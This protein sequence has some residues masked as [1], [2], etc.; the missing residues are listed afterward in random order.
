MLYKVFL[1]ED[2]IVTRE[3]I[4]DN[5][6]WK[7]A[8]FEFCGEAPDGEM[9]LPLIEAT[10]PDLLITDIKMPFMDGLQLCKIIREHMP[11]IKIIILSGHDEFNY[12]QTAIKL[13][14]AEYLLKPVS[15]KDLHQV[16]QRTVVKLDQERIERERLKQLREQLDD[17]L[18]LIR[19]KFLLRLVLGGVS[20]AEAIEQSEQLG[21]DL[22]A[23]YYLALLIKTE[24]PESSQPNAYQEYQ[25]VGHTI[26][27][28]VG[29]NPDILWAQ[30]DL[31]ELVLLMKGDNLEQLNQEA[32]FLAGLIK[33]EVEEKMSCV[34]RIGLGSPQQRLGEIHHSYAEALAKAGANEKAP[35]QETDER[36]DAI[37]HAKLDQAALE[38]YLKSGS[39]L[40]FNLFFDVY[41]QPVSEAAQRSRLLKQYI[42]LDILLTAAQFVSDLGGDAN[43]VLPEIGQV[44]TLMEG[45]K[46][47]DEIKGEIRKILT[48]V[49]SF[50]DGQVDNHQAQVIH[51]AQDYIDHHFFD[52][53]LSLQ[54][55][56]AQVNLSASH[57]SVVFS[58]AMGETYRDYLTRVRIERAKELLRTTDLMCAEIAYRCGYNDPHYFS[59]IF[60]KNTGVTPQKFRVQPRDRKP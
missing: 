25:Q 49:L 10:Q 6:D 54:Q 26:L 41:L 51:H 9:A 46:T 23:S 5:V 50:R 38:H 17:N 39:A 34:L 56:A 40:D 19:E 59:Y 53:D 11:W 58:Q 2:E 16:L 4:R 12:A 37:E 14:V 28:L 22:I 60:K 18:L 27:G 1:V 32:V 8:G 31:E 20:S 36:L 7:A 47:L 44:E 43:Q 52:A 55:V 13:G 45:I 33:Q 30:K 48:A 24:L 57:F 15:V 35:A 42:F 29:T 21:L 3:G